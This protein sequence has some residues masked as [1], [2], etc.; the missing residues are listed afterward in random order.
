MDGQNPATAEWH[1]AASRYLNS[2]MDAIQPKNSGRNSFTD[3][4][5]TWMAHG[6]NPVANAYRE[7]LEFRRN[8][9]SGNSGQVLDEKLPLNYLQ[10]QKDG[11]EWAAQ[12]AEA[13]HPQTGDWLYDDPVELAK[14][15]RKGPDMPENDNT[16]VIPDGLIAAVNRLLDSDGSRGCYDAM[17]LGEA[18]DEIERLLAAAPAVSDGWIPV[19]ERL[20]EVGSTI[21]VHM[22]NPQYSATDYAIATYDK[23]GF[24]RAKVTHWQPL[25]DAPK[26]V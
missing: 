8:A 21:M 24:S 12:M 4:E 1:S 26:G 2:Y 9:A 7:L 19:S 18:R 10:G 6:D 20:P 13:S 22:D 11:L 17:V 25:P 14:A 5:L 15:I 3:D 16:L 23:Y